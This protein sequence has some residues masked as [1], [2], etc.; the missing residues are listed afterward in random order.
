MQ[1]TCD[2]LETGGP[3]VTV[4][5][6]ATV[7]YL[8]RSYCNYQHLPVRA[9]TTNARARRDDAPL[10]RMYVLPALVN[11][12]KFAALHSSAIYI[13]ASSRTVA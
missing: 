12:A 1:S 2:N 5:V 10:M 4:A 11:V 8:T 9:T 7:L 13:L 3:R 6:F